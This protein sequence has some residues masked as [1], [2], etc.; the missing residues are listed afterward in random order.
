M[1]VKEGKKEA[2]LGP[3]RVDQSGCS[4]WE[5][6]SGQSGGYLDD[7]L[8]RNSSEESGEANKVIFFSL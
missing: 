4:E 8:H 6:H 7:W 2:F 1:I 3:G 5:G